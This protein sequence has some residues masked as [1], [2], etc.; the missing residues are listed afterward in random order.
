MPAVRIV[1][2]LTSTRVYTHTR[3]RAFTRNKTGFPRFFTEIQPAYELFFAI[4]CSQK[5]NFPNYSIDN[6]TT[7]QKGMSTDFA[8]FF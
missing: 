7:P 4:N 5:Q 2:F 8:N 6:Y 3:T 1:L